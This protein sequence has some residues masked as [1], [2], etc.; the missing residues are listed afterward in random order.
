LKHTKPKVSSGCW[1][2]K[3]SASGFLYSGS[4]L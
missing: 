4:I 2:Y 3:F 1:G